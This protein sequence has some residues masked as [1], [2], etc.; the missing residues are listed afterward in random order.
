VSHFLFKEKIT[1][2]AVIGTMIALLGVVLLFL[3]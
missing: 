2:R 3:T 1:A